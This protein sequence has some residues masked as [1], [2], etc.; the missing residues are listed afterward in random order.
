METI[1]THRL[2]WDGIGLTIRHT[3]RRWTVIDHLEIEADNR[4][5]LPIT[6]TGYRSH[7]LDPG[8]IDSCGGALALVSQWLDDAAAAGGWRGRQ[9]AL[10]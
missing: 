3:R 7:F 10:F 5:P 6:E 9:L 8:I 4:Q 1:E 2:F